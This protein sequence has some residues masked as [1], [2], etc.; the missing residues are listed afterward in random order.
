MESPPDDLKNILGPNEQIQLYIQEKIYHPR[1]NIDSIV[2]TNE[3]IILR[4]PHALGLKKDYTDYN[5]QD[6]ANVVLKKGVLRSGLRCTL[7]LGGEPLM[8]DDL[9]NSD[10]EKAYGIIR[11]NLVR[12]QTP[13]TA[14]AAGVPP[15]LRQSPS[16]SPSSPA[17]KN[18]GSPL[19]AGQKFCG[20]CG[21]PV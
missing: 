8:L 1:I 9:P 4:H 2:I 7:R 6:V 11:E 15:V 13:F 14:V 3:R 21:Q 20:T 12:Y 19:V 5:Y 16:P 18:C 17:C 10:A